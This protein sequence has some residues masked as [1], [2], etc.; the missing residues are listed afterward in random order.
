[1]PALIQSLG[2]ALIFAAIW[3]R[4]CDR[5]NE[6]IGKTLGAGI[7]LFLIGGLMS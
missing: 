7:V 6:F 4:L 3:L 5:N 2:A 1:V